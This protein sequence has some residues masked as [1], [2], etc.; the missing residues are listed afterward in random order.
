MS[1]EQIDFVRAFHKLS[2]EEK[3]KLLENMTEEERQVLTKLTEHYH[4]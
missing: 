1:E 4:E 2:E 3:S